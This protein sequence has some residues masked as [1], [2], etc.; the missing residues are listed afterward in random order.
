VPKLT[1]NA[2]SLVKALPDYIQDVKTYYKSELQSNSWMDS[3][4]IQRLTVSISAN[5]NG[6]AASLGTLIIN[7]VVVTLLKLSRSVL[8]WVL[9]MA[10]SFYILSTTPRALHGWN[11][12]LIKRLGGARAKQLFGLW[13]QM[14]HVCGRYIS[15]KLLE[16]LIIYFLCQAAF[17]LIP[18]PYGLL[19]SLL[20]AAAN[21]VPYIG[22]LAGGAVAVF[23]AFL[24]NPL[25]ALWT[26]GAIAV[27]K[28][29]DVLVIAPRLV[30][31]KLGLHPFWVLATVLL[32][33][34][35]A[36]VPGMLFAVPIA[37]V[38]KVLLQ[39]SME[40]QREERNRRKKEEEQKIAQGP[41]I[42]VQ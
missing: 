18:L 15:A 34:R 26:A 41:D 7:G 42:L 11:K 21:V 14:D 40:R 9:A 2:I 13:K 5:L 33:A 30:G 29:I 22:P 32:G 19:M 36:G 4:V 23:I 10:L 35:I 31:D 28:C 24:E 20:V 25:L 37:A 6:I 39:R 1:N 3:Q 38:A 27:I 17:L 8:T 12:F 16:S